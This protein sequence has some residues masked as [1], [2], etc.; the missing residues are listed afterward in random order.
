MNHVKLRY[1]FMSD[2][3][4]KTPF[5]L[6]LFSAFKAERRGSVKGD[7][8]MRIK[9]PIAAKRKALNWRAMFSS[10]YVCLWDFQWR[11]YYVILLE[12]PTVFS[13]GLTVR[14]PPRRTGFNSRPVTPRFSQ[15]R[16]VLDDAAGRRV[17]LG[18]L[19]FPSPLHS[20]SINF[21]HH[22]TLIGSQD[23]VVK[24]ATWVVHRT[25]FAHRG[26]ETVDVRVS[27]APNATTRLGVRGA[28][29]LRPDG[30]LKSRPNISTEI[31]CIAADRLYSLTYKY[32]DINWFSA[33]T[34]E[35]D[36]WAS[37]LQEVSNIV[38]RALAELQQRLHNARRS[39]R[40]H[41]GQ[42]AARPA[43]V[44]RHLV[45][46][47]SVAEHTPRG[48]GIGGWLGTSTSRNYRFGPLM[49]TVLW[50][51]LGR[52]LASP[53]LSQSN[54]IQL[55]RQTRAPPPSP[56][57]KDFY[58]TCV[59]VLDPVMIHLSLYG[60]LLRLG[61][62]R[63]QATEY[64]G[65]QAI[66]RSGALATNTAT[67]RRKR[68]PADYF[69]GLVSQVDLV[70]APVV[71]KFVSSPRLLVRFCDSPGRKY[72]MS[73]LRGTTASQNPIL[74]FQYKYFYEMGKS[75]FSDNIF[76]L[77]Y[78]LFV[79]G[80]G[81]CGEEGCIQAASHFHVNTRLRQCARK[82]KMR[83]RVDCRGRDPIFLC[84]NTGVVSASLPPF[85]HS[86]D[87]R[88]TPRD[89]GL[90]HHARR[91][92]PITNG[93]VVPARRT[94]HGVACVEC[95]VSEPTQPLHHSA[96]HILSHTPPDTSSPL[97]RP[98]FFHLPFPIPSHS[99]KKK[100][101]LAG[102]PER[103][104]DIKNFGRMAGTGLERR[105]SQT[106]AA[107]P[108][109]PSSVKCGTVQSA[110]HLFA[111]DAI[112]PTTAHFNYS[113]QTAVGLLVSHLG[114]PGSI[115]GRVTPDFC[116]WK[117]WRTMVGGFL[118][119][120]PFPPPLHSGA[121]PFSLNFTLIGSQDL[122][123]WYVLTLGALALDKVWRVWG[124]VSRVCKVK[125]G[126]ILTW[127]R[128]AK[129]VHI[130]LASSR[131]PP[132][133]PAQS[134]FSSEKRIFLQ[135]QAPPLSL[136]RRILQNLP[137]TKH[138][139]PLPLHQATERY[140]LAGELP[141]P[142]RALHNP[143]CEARGWFECVNRTGDLFR[144][145]RLCSSFLSCNRALADEGR[146]RSFVKGMHHPCRTV[147]KQ[148]VCLARDKGCY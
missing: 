40:L 17:F 137:K 91:Q 22:L 81:G 61:T 5:Y 112:Y 122:Q 132:T 30:H 123:L 70:F 101:P 107:D 88:V 37:V 124:Q 15:M 104:A 126:V 79:M 139:D 43:T 127:R 44:G 60:H 102:S 24:E 146:P 78:S 72:K 133:T 58:Y 4:V 74:K 83:I 23:H 25:F 57:Y 85:Y 145:A 115:P 7:T 99:K 19:P 42:T 98:G 46:D 27:I 114:E 96:A 1:A 120:L 33:V 55:H 12:H 147:F 119:D 121:A 100:K 138:P 90:I 143:R 80:R 76:F 20:D 86:S 38:V 31:N 63:C 92:E 113:T 95:N 32:E 59:E 68:R 64:S 67:Q 94:A 36:D 93:V 109:S 82:R 117:S 131:P 116:K 9:S 140:L 110:Y 134:T 14:L 54:E 28:Q 106:F 49:L 65:V 69:I 111:I 97:Q 148:P 73:L 105:P 29:F 87:C 11:S 108:L 45:I 136:E 3:A 50:V 34:V 118:G 84:R 129:T 71:K 53:N 51:R 35:A 41:G 16:I 144:L 39:L 52:W 77:F 75:I 56:L 142:W 10:C 141:G 47:T 2:H 130:G 62:T 21:S 26:D 66:H 18:D 103:H 128:T 13:S 125:V 8:A 135:G 48:G 89:R 6:E